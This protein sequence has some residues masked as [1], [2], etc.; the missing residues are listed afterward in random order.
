MKE[1]KMEIF[2]TNSIDMMMGEYLAI[3]GA[4]EKTVR[5]QKK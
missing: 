2:P 1:N 4:Q 5:L 3:F